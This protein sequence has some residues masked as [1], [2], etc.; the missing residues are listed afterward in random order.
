MWQQR[1][2]EATP[3]T[4]PQNVALGMENLGI[5]QLLQDLEKE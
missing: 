2:A 3:K 5:E 1:W 4:L